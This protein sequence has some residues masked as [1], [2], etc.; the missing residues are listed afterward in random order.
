MQVSTYLSVLVLDCVI[1]SLFFFVHL[2]VFDE[3]CWLELMIYD[4]WV[5]DLRSKSQQGQ[6]RFLQR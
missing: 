5:P 2:E 4:Y 6:G 1:T 3:G